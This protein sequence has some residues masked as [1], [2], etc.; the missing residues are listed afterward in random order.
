[1]NDAQI[2]SN[3][4]RLIRRGNY[5][6]AAIYY[7]GLNPTL[8]AQPIVAL[9]AARASILQGNMRNA[10]ES[11]RK[12]ASTGASPGETLILSLESASLFVFRSGAIREA[13][14]LARS[15][16]KQTSH[17]KLTPLEW[18]EAE[19]IR[20]RLWLMAS[21][22]FEMPKQ[23]AQAAHQQLPEIADI[24]MDGGL[25][26]ESLAA[27]LLYVDH[28]E[29]PLL[30]I[31][32]L[33]DLAQ[34]ALSVNALELA[35]E[36]YLRRAE[37]KFAQSAESA[38]IRAD[39]DESEMLYAKTDHLHGWID[40][41]AVRAKLAIEREWGSL[42]ELGQC[43]SNYEKIQYGRGLF[44]VLLDLSQL[45][46]WRGDITGARNYR[47][48]SLALAEKMDMGLVKD[49]FI[50][51][52]VDIC[53]RLNDYTTAIEMCES[54]IKSSPS[55]MMVASFEQLLAT[56]YS[57]V[58]N[59]E[60]A[61]LHCEKA[62]SIFES[63]GAHESASNAVIKFANDLIGQRSDLNWFEAEKRLNDW[64]QKDIGLGYYALAVSKYELLAQLDINR[65]NFSDTQRGERAL[66]ERAEQTL[67]QGEAI[68]QKLTGIESQRRLGGLYQLRGQIFQGMGD[69]AGV[70][71][72]WRDALQ[73]YE[74]AGLG[75]EAANCHHII[76]VLRLNLANQDVLAHFGEAETQLNAS[77]SYYDQSGM[78]RQSADSRFML[79][80]LYVN[81]SLQVIDSF[82]DQLITAAVQQLEAAEIDY[83]DVRREFAAGSILDVQIGKRA[84][85]SSSQRIYQLIREIHLL[86]RP[87][88]EQAWYWVQ[89]AK[90]RAL[91]DA[92]GAGTRIP[93]RILQS[94][95]ADQDALALVTREQELSI[96][97]QAESD[98]RQLLREELTALHAQMA[99]VPSLDE[100]MDVRLS[101]PVT[102][103]DLKKIC[104]N[105]DG[106][107]IP[108]VC[109]DWI[110][111][112]DQLWLFTVRP[113]EMPHATPLELSL[114]EAQS[115]V[116]SSLTLS[117]R[118]TLRDAPILLQQMK[119]LIAPLATLTAPEELLVLS[120]HAALYAIPLHALE[121]DGQP[122]LVRNP[123][124]YSASLSVL[125]HCR[126]RQPY[127]SDMTSVALFGDPNA[128]RAASADLI[129]ELGELFGTTPLMNAA[130]TRDAFIDNI[131]GRDLIHFQGHAMHDP[132]SPLDS[133]LIFANKEKLTAQDIFGLTGIVADLVTLGA[134]ESAANVIEPGDEPL[135]LV[136]AF[137]YAGANSIV[138][139]LWRVYSDSA[140]KLMRGFYSRL[141]AKE[142]VTDKAQCLRQ[143]ML[144]LRA[145]PGFETPYHWAP[146]VLH[147]NWE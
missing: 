8:Q 40:V 84:F 113:G 130:V 94:L 60:A 22:Y 44:N 7:S 125:R 45:S 42:S 145:T 105:R 103:D 38:S 85:T 74:K 98:E 29:N 99:Q 100:Y 62:I 57:F 69:V 89:R 93:A 34:R 146:Y 20:T 141:S 1:M 117:Y 102:S 119:A 81:G 61:S 46:H 115:F 75:Y 132:Q 127:S 71:R 54:A 63:L 143:A 18:A 25:V 122:L 79:A 41:A 126:A 108:C 59:R 109:V 80:R 55:M 35:A 56:S 53:M 118:Q 67:I 6:E 101:T 68:A 114:S 39:L 91:T 124:T 5:V 66:L 129:T 9:T 10:Y 123:I 104:T 97:I 37:R 17:V 86:H 77:L 52:Q 90:A 83:D 48:Q 49:N 82:S 51:A 110:S 43:L 58:N 30:R 47:T 87:D 50:L 92:M 14:A 106:D 144:E 23:E 28:L 16:L 136:P 121:I 4:Q 116:Q 78:R 135:G 13:V 27:S 142:T 19:R 26:D 2:V 112:D 3:I 147:G 137:L 140:A 111:L 36:V 131:K 72:A 138:A 31:D 95:N 133:H 15:A 12:A 65:F 139:T 73:V 76:G 24:L 134:C 107:L 128:D 120:P 32:A 64:A 33:R 21:T 88:T 11:L 96:R 70:E